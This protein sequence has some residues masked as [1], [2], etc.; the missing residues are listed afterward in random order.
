MGIDL[1]GKKELEETN[2]QAQLLLATLS[3]LVREQAPKIQEIVANLASLTAHL[4][5]LAAKLDAALK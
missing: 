5:A 3:A 2:D 1:L 4:N